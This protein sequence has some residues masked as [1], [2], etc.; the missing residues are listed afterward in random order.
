METMGDYLN[1][2]DLLNA[3]GMA[4]VW[5]PNGRLLRLGWE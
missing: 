2:E 3:I 1:K 4:M 5:I